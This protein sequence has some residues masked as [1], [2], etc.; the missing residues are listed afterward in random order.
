MQ[1]LR[2]VSA[3]YRRWWWALVRKNVVGQMEALSLVRRDCREVKVEAVRGMEKCRG[4]NV[5]KAR[6]EL[7]GGMG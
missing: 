2:D 3:G 7:G 5:V 4:R 6:D 1:E